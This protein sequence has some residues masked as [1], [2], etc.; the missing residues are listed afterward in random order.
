MFGEVRE[1]ARVEKGAMTYAAMFKPEVRLLRRH[2]ANHVARTAAL[3]TPNPADIVVLLSS[4]GAPD[5]DLPREPPLLDSFYLANVDPDAS[6]HG[7]AV[8][9]KILQR[10]GLHL[11][12]TLR[13]FHDFFSSPFRSPRSKSDPS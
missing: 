7:A 6:A 9:F 1:F 11:G 13:A 8:D 5:I 10:N 12:S 3:G 2:H 4:S